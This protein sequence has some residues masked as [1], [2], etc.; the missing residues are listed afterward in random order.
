MRVVFTSVRYMVTDIHEEITKGVY[1][2]LPPVIGYPFSCPS[3]TVG[4]DGFMCASDL[5]H[6]EKG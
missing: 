4:R 3:H 5:S 1:T 2:S 6:Q